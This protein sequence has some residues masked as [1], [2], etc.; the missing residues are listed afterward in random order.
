LTS[1]QSGK[2][3]K[4]GCCTP[5]TSAVIPSPCAEPEAAGF[6]YIGFAREAVLVTSTVGVMIGVAV[7]VAEI[8][9]VLV[10]PGVLVMTTVMVIV[11]RV[12]VGQGVGVTVGIGR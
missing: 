11:S 6:L 12:G 9:I 3:T 10:T 4:H 5:W 1:T 7:T 8:M 2:R